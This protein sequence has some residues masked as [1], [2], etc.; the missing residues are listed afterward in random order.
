MTI[1]IMFVCTFIVNVGAV[2]CE[3]IVSNTGMPASMEK[4]TED[5]QEKISELPEV[6]VEAK[7]RRVLHILAY[8]REY[9]SLTSYT[10]T[11]TMFREKMVDFMIPVDKK[12]RFRG[13][14]YPRVLK[15]KSYYQFTNA[16]SLD[17][18]SDRCNNHFTWSDWIG[19]FPTMKIPDK[20]TATEYGADTLSGKYSPTEVWRRD[21]DRLTVDVDVLADASGRRWVPDISPFFKNEVADFDQFRVRLNYDNVVGSEIGSLDLVNYSFNISAVR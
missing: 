21:G 1:L 7:H 19:L 11:I 9:S 4:S 6:I 2:C 16:N 5:R 17:S 15:T 3:M 8:V 10:D 12:T 18:V 13:W 20:L 14:K